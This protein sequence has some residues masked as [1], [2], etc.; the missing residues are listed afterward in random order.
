MKRNPNEIVCTGIDTFASINGRYA[1]SVA[2]VTGDNFQIICRPSK[3]IGRLVA[4]V[5]MARSVKSVSA[6]FLRFILY[7]NLQL[8]KPG[9]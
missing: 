3:E 9:Q 6:D 5:L 8:P 2:E 4:D 1:A 7:R